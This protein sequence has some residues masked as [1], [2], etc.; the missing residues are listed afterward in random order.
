V[1]TQEGFTGSSNAIYQY[2]I[3]YAHETTLLTDIIPE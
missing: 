2:L 3:K 1:I